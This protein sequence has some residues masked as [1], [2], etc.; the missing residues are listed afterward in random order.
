MVNPTVEM[1]SRPGKWYG[2]DLMRMEMIPEFI[3]HVNLSKSL[4][5][6]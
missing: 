3:H 2:Q 4:S 5:G 1:T 6:N